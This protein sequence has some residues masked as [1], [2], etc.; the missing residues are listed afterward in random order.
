MFNI[1]GVSLGD[2]ILCYLNNALF[3]EIEKIECFNHSISKLLLA[4]DVVSTFAPDSMGLNAVLGIQSK[5]NNIMSFVVSHGTVTKQTNEAKIEWDEHSKHLMGGLFT[6]IAVQTYAQKE[7]LI[8]KKQNMSRTVETGPLIYSNTVN[9]KDIKLK[10]KLYGIDNKII[11][12]HAGTPSS[13]KF[14]SPWVFETDDEY[15]SSVN[16]IIKSL[17]RVQSAYLVVK[18]RKKHFPGMENK[19]IRELFV[20]SPN[21]EIFIDGLFEEYLS[22][23]DLLV[24]YSSTTIEEALAMKIP[25]LQ[26]SC[27]NKYMHLQ[28]PTATK[29]QELDINP[30]YYCG[31]KDEL[32][33]SFDIILKNIDLIKLEKY[34][35]NL[36]RYPIDEN[37]EW[38]KILQGK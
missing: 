7:F 26:Y 34:K 18:V 30:I 21:S 37:F 35:W 32:K 38:F 27:D 28:A 19:D 15:I 22:T 33:D 24:S 31:S 29:G 13:F 16:D 1:Y 3:S 4:G 14:F 20:D 2:S 36:Y 23:A 17:S 6:F 10:N 12:L 25:V 9:Y 8:N 5:K 11:I